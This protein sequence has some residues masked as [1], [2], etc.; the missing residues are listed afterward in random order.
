MF[1]VRASIPGILNW[2][3]IW[4][5]NIYSALS[6]ANTGKFTCWIRSF[7]C[8]SAAG[9]HSRKAGINTPLVFLLVGCIIFATHQLFLCA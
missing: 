9:K 4:N 8:L 5:I 1:V 7:D 2:G 6:Y 3:V